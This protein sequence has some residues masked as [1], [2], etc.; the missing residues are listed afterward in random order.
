MR[1]HT[2]QLI[3]SVENHTIRSRG[4]SIVNIKIAHDGVF[5]V[6]AANREIEALI[7]MVLVRVVVD[8]V[9]RLVKRVSL[10][11]G[12]ANI[13]GPVAGASAGILAAFTALKVVPCGGR[14]ER[15][16]KKEGEKGDDGLVEIPN[17]APLSH[18]SGDHRS[19]P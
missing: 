10:G 11:L 14:S 4:A 12:C 18:G 2:R 1:D 6:G 15:G 7:V 13:A 19:V 16:G 5:V 17:L 8:S 9:P 3:V